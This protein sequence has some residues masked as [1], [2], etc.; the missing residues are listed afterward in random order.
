VARAKGD[1]AQGKEVKAF[2]KKASRKRSRGSEDED[3]DEEESVRLD[4]DGAMAR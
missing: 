3:R 4:R 2:S 1:K